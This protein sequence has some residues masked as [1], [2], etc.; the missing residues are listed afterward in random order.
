MMSRAHELSVVPHV[1]AR[2]ARRRRTRYVTRRPSRWALRTS[3][4]SAPTRRDD[5]AARSR[6]RQGLGRILERGL[7]ASARR[8]HSSPSSRLA[9][10][11][12]GDRGRRSL[13]RGHRDRPARSA[14][15]DAA[16]ARQARRSRRAGER[17]DSLAGR[18]AR[19]G[20]TAGRRSMDDGGR[21]G[22][23]ARR[24]R[25]ACGGRLSSRARSPLKSLRSRSTTA[26]I[27]PGSTTRASS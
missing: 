18:A 13:S 22:R 14:G 11:R 9:P 25:Q 27:G 20:R 10:R 2:P 24:R 1:S 26:S 16:S 3:R 12:C 7:W 23:R 4:A 6:P 17:R 15:P 21:R 19:P 8:R 5:D